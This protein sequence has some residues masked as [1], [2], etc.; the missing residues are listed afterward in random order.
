M[1]NNNL[2][3]LKGQLTWFWVKVPTSFLG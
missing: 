2:L 3:D 1:N